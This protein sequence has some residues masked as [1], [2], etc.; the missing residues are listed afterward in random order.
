MMRENDKQVLLV[1]T[2][3]LA[4]SLGLSLEPHATNIAWAQW[5]SVRGAV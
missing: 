4:L 5:Q 1:N 3:R 2:I